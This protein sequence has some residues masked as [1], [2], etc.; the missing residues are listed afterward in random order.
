MAKLQHILG[1]Q[2]GED[3]PVSIPETANIS[4]L[5][6]VIKTERSKLFDNVD[7]STI[8]LCTVP[9]GHDFSASSKMLPLP[10]LRG[11]LKVRIAFTN[12]DNEDVVHV[13]IEP[14]AGKFSP[15]L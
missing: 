15:V 12:L 5:R 9:K 11:L 6:S 8:L 2:E 14:P 4:Q 10:N 3:F 13:L 1:E 7:A